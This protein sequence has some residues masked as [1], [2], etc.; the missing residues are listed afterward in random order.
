MD[1]SEEAIEA[2]VQEHDNYFRKIGIRTYEKMWGKIIGVDKDNF[3]FE[4]ATIS[5]HPKSLGERWREEDDV[6]HG[7]D[8]E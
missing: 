5:R 8:V 6:A 3:Y 4:S 7:E 1:T 2:A